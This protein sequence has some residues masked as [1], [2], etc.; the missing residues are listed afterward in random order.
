MEGAREPNGVLGEMVVVG[1]GLRVLVG[2][3]EQA[4]LYCC[5]LC[6]LDDQLRRQ[7]GS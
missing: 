3:K 1:Q 6:R 7:C 2:D 4:F 5:A